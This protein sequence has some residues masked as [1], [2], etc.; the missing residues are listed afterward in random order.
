MGRRK[1]L[2]KV[3]KAHNDT[4]HSEGLSERQISMIIKVG[5]SAV[6]QA[7]KKFQQYGLH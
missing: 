7:N 6:H 3:Q 1:S 2:N 5:Y 4:Q